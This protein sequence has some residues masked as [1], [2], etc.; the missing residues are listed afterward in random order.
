ME[1]FA[2]LKDVG[3]GLLHRVYYSRFY[4]SNDKLRPAW[5]KDPQ[6]QKVVRGL[7]AKFPEFP[8]TEKVLCNKIGCFIITSL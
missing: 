4:F 8:D 3:E 1:K 7:V 5:L 2:Y 6:I